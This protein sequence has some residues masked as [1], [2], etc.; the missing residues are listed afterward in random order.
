MNRTNRLDPAVVCLLS[1]FAVLGTSAQG[2]SAAEPVAV[3]EAGALQ[4]TP[5]LELGLGGFSTWGVNFGAGRQDQRSGAV[6]GDAAWVEGYA[7]PGLNLDYAAP[8]GTLYGGVSAVG[9]FTGGEGDAGGYTRS[10]DG[11][12]AWE[13]AFLGWRSAGLFADRW[14]DDTLDLSY[15]R[16][17]FAVG[18]GF[19]IQDGNLDQFDKGAYW[20]APRRAFREAAL[21]RLNTAPVRADAFYLAADRDQDET[22]VAGV[23]LEYASAARG[24]FGLMY[25]QVVDSGVPTVFGA[26]DGMEVFS[27]R[28]AEVTLPAAPGLAL[29]GEYVSERGSGRDGAVDARAWYLE[30]K[31]EFSELPWS[32]SLS[33]RY[34]RFSGDPDPDDAVRRDFDPFFYGWSRGWGTWFQ[35]ELTGEYLLFNSNQVNHMLHLAAAPSEATSLGL[36][37]YRFEL[38]QGNYFGTPVSDRHFADELNLYLDWAVSE[39]LSVSAAYGIAFPG[40]A[41]KEAFGE[42]PFQVLQLALYLSL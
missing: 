42:D 41:A 20:L 30:G 8:V 32:P 38:D 34:A 33:Y 35:G 40:R 16:Q 18:D 11:G 12:V 23:N 1:G 6:T 9:A 29:W 3:P 4:L 31:Y 19:L 10:G 26:R 22:E 39:Q 36:I 17:E 25:F 37:A 2:G 15:G 24:S 7:K 5:G 28:A 21:F 27:L 14:G 13:T